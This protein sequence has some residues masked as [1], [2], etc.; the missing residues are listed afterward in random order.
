[1]MQIMS[2]DDKRLTERMGTPIRDSPQSPSYAMITRANTP[3]LSVE[4]TPRRLSFEEH[5]PKMEKNLPNYSGEEVIP[6]SSD[7]SEE[8]HVSFLN[9]NNIRDLPPGGFLGEETGLTRN[10]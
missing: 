2:E 9:K 8:K 1:M 5:F 4:T 3:I 7:E 10:G 6:I